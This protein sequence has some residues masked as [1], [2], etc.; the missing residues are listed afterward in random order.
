MSSPCSAM[1]EP[2]DY[3]QVVY[4]DPPWSYRGQ[5][6]HGGA[7][8]G[9]TSGA[10]EFYATM[11]VEDICTQGISD[12]NGSALFMWFSPPIMEDAL[13]VMRAWG[14]KY[15]TI[16]HV[17][18]KQRVNPGAYTLSSCEMVM[19]GTRKKRPSPRSM[20]ERQLVT[21]PRTRHSAK[22]DEVRESIERMYPEARRVEL[23][24]R[25]EQVDHWTRYGL[26]CEPKMLLTPEGPAAV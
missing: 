20:K 11:S 8:Q 6:Q 16:S 4:C 24:A 22:P 25:G 2:A 9:F 12:P 3:F 13:A 7:H 1:G 5:V 26:E 14:F 17:W 18:N 23:F 21:V 10:S 19:V 15:K